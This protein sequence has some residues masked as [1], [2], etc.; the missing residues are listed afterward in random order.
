MSSRMTRKCFIS[1]H[2]DDQKHVDQFV[3]TFD[4]QRGI[5]IARALGVMDQNIIDSTDTDYIMRRIREKYLTDSTVTIVLIGRCTWARRYVDWEI[6]STLRNDPNN[7]RSGL[8]GITLPYM[9]DQSKT[10]PPRLDDNVKSGDKGYAKWYKYPTS[11]SGLAEIIEEA[12][13]ARD[14][15][16]N[17]IDNIRSLA[18]SNKDC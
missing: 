14:T 9:A 3:K 2:H 8:V 7:K 15:K 11:S 1:Y 6:A 13:E 5:F 10:L 12:Y 18:R 16:A 4:E 17:L